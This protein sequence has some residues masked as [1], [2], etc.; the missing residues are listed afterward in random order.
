MQKSNYK[1]RQKF[2]DASL[3][4]DKG[5]KSFEN[6]FHTLMRKNKRKTAALYFDEDD[7]Q[8]TF[9][10]KELEERVRYISRH[11]NG[12]FMDFGQD[13]IIALKIKN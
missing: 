5:P 11:L 12:L 1:E 6:I 2:L 13:E 9:T 10:Y 8:K 7:R 4:L 3:L